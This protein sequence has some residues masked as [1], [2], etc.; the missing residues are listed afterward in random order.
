MLFHISTQQISENRSVLVRTNIIASLSCCFTFL[1]VDVRAVVWRTLRSCT[2]KSCQPLS[3]HKKTNNISTLLHKSLLKLLC[4][5]CRF[6]IYN[7]FLWAFCGRELYM[8]TCNYDQCSRSMCLFTLRFISSWWRLDVTSRRQKREGGACI[9]LW[10]LLCS[11]HVAR[12]FWYKSKDKTWL[13]LM[14]GF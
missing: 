11:L 12:V 10:W 3:E 5:L 9:K 8:Y 13:I 6:R 14:V 4:I 1:Y 2:F 7:N